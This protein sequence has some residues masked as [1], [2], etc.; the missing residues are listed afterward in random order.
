MPCLH[1]TQHNCSNWTNH[2][3]IDPKPFNVYLMYR[4][5]PSAKAVN[6]SNTH[7]PYVLLFVFCLLFNSLV[8]FT[9]IFNFPAVEHL[10]G[11]EACRRNSFLVIYWRYRQ[12]TVASQFNDQLLF[13]RKSWCFIYMVDLRT[14]HLFLNVHFFFEYSDDSLQL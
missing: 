4:Y 12:F 11:A 6:F 2:G 10:V 3:V 5:C 1:N 9:C 7:F 13:V 8:I 14:T